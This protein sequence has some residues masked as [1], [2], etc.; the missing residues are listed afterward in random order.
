[1]QIFYDFAA[2]P[3]KP[4]RPTSKAPSKGGDKKDA[5]TIPLF[6]QKNVISLFNNSKYL[7]EKGNL[8][9]GDWEN[10]FW[11][12]IKDGRRAV[13]VYEPPCA[14][15]Y[16]AVFTTH[17]LNLPKQNTGIF[18]KLY[19]DYRLSLVKIK[20]F[21]ENYWSKSSII[22]ALNTLD[23]TKHKAQ[24]M[25]YGYKAQGHKVVPH[26]KEQQVIKQMIRLHTNGMSF[27]KI[28]QELINQNIK[29]KKGG[30]WDKS[31]VATI[32]RREIKNKENS[33]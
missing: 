28:T 17:F 24:K 31:I 11:L 30:K 7:K 18:R 25:R 20:E 5:D 13:P 22:D 6:Q 14:K 4:K 10:N 23:I 29:T 1:M 26:L 3:K 9:S 15:A 2:D 33:L 19:V 32:I 8:D 21:S 12:S 27:R 16:L